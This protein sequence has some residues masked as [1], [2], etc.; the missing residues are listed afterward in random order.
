[1][2][3]RGRRGLVDL[4]ALDADE[5]IFDVVDAA[6]AVSACHDVELLDQRDWVEPL[7]V[8][9]NGH[10]ALEADD[11]LDRIGC[12]RRVDGPAVN[13]VARRHPGILQ[14]SRFDR[15]APQVH[16]DRVDRLLGYRDLDVPCLCVLDLLFAR[17]THADPHRGDDCERWVEG[18]GGDIEA[19]LVVALAGAAVG[20]RLRSLLVGH[21]DKELGNQWASHGRGQRV[22]ALVQGAGLDVRPAEVPHEALPGVDDISAHGPGA[23]WPGDRCPPGARRRPGRR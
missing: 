14:N 1:M 15:S 2:D 11:D 9:R 10:A 17:Q 23:R 12:L 21:L 6:D 4:P 8:E 19:D 20:D 16:I 22:D 7:A 5:P 18:M 3:D 13:V